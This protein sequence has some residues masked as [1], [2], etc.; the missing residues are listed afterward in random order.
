MRRIFVKLLSLNGRAF[1]GES[2]NSSSEPG[3]NIIV[4]LRGCQCEE[5]CNFEVGDDAVCN[6]RPEK[7]ADQG[8]AAMC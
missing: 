4:E 1:A 3:V 6:D 7:A 8:S 5:T 2:A